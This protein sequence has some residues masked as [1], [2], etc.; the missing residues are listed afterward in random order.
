MTDLTNITISSV[1]SAAADSMMETKLFKQ[2]A[3]ALTFAA[4][5]M[6]KHHMD[7]FSPDVY[8]PADSE[9]TNYAFSTLDTEGKWAALIK[10]LYPGCT[11]PYIYL[12]ALM[13][14]GCLLV[15]QRMKD[16]PAYSLLDEL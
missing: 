11:T 8:T 9:G 13:D 7:S 16:D 10:A 15:A 12:R 1:A 6:I 14:K 4:G 5:Y 3:D 2:K